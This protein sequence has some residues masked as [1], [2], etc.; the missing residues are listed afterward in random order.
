[1]TRRA[2]PVENMLMTRVKTVEKLLL[3]IYFL[4]VVRGLDRVDTVFA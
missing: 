1:M 2:R 4:G 3:D